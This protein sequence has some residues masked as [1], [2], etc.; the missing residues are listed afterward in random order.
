MKRILRAT[1]DCY[2][3]NRIIDNAFRATDAN[4]G[5]GGTLDIFKL[6]GESIY[7]GS[8]PFVAG[9]TDAI[10]LSRALI[11]FDLNPIAALTSSVLNIAHSSFKCMLRLYDVVGGQTLPSNFTLALYPLSQSFDEGIGRDVSSYQDI[12]AANYLTASVSSGLSVWNLSGAGAMGYVG[13][14]AIDVM[15]GSMVLGDLFVTQTFTVGDE[16]LAMDVT[17]IVSASL[18]GLLANHGYRISFSGTQETD[19][20]TRFVKRFATRHST[21]PQLRPMIE[22]G[23]DDAINDHHKCFFFDTSGSLFMNSSGRSAAANI[24]SGSALTQ[25]T[26]TNSLLLILRSGSNASGTFF[27]TQVSASQHFVGS[28]AVTGVYSASLAISSHASSTLRNEIVNAGSA[29]FTEIWGSLDGSV[30]YFT[31]SVV[32]K[33]LDVAAF[34]RSIDTLT[35]NITNMKRVFKRSEKLRTR[36]VA[37]DDGFK[38][39][40]TK[41]PISPESLVFDQMHYRLVD[42]STDEFVYDFDTTNYSTKLSTDTKGMYFDLFMSDLDVGRSYCIDIMLDFMG[43]I[44]V[45]KRVGGTFRIEA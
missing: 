40:A 14:S 12:D 30:G 18:A 38:L 42:A 31:G 43:A 10:E 15:T 1:A 26:G 20:T 36:V 16:D 33:S 28:M 24:V 13:Q 3:T 29:T 34:D 25:I 6:A 4:V 9:T 35:I 27:S 5:L 39:R 44:R 8:S 32:V 2:I 19:A 45:F 7:T 41:L 11:R 22:V 23:F 17:R 37:Y 21:N